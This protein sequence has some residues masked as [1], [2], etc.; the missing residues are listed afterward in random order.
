MMQL[1]RRIKKMEI[2]VNPNNYYG[3]LLRLVRKYYRDWVGKKGAEVKKLI[4]P[5]IIAWYEKEKLSKQ[6][7][8]E[9]AI[10]NI[11]VNLVNEV[12]DNRLFQNFLTTE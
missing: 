8:L 12:T 5:E 11:Y 7:S 10:S 6:I 2:T 1:N 4:E 3:L 9:V